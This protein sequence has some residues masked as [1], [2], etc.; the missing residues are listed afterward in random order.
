[1]TFMVRV[2]D[3]QS[4]RQI[5]FGFLASE[6]KVAFIRAVRNRSGSASTDAMT[7][8]SFESVG[9]LDLKSDISRQYFGI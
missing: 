8:D 6:D 9:P 5:I 1:M 3:A 7:T 2:L 4:S